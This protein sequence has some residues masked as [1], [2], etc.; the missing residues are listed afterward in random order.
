MKCLNLCLVKSNYSYYFLYTFYSIKQKK[1]LCD[2]IFLSLFSF[3]LVSFLPNGP[4]S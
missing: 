2:P 4:L 1:K 3:L